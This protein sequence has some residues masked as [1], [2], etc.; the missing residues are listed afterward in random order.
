M[1]YD[2]P[3]HPE[4][5]VGT[6]FYGGLTSIADEVPGLEGL[7]YTFQVAVEEAYDKQTRIPSR[8]WGRSDG[9]DITVQFGSF[10]PARGRFKKY[11]SGLVLTIASGRWR[12][13]DTRTLIAIG[14]QY[15]ANENISFY[16]AAS[17][18]D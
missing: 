4:S 13:R 6:Q 12:I 11:H 15:A 18:N 14:Q 7:P 2:E 3:I 16:V 9:T 8:T 5:L 17:Q 10:F 1:D